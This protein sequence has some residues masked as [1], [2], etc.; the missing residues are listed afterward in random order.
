MHRIEELSFAFSYPAS[1]RGLIRAIKCE[2]EDEVADMLL[3]DKLLLIH[4]EESKHEDACPCQACK[5]GDD[6]EPSHLNR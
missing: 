1:V 5:E 4:A 6:C 3:R 2:T